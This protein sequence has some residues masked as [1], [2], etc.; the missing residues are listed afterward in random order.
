MFASVVAPYDRV[1]VGL[2]I[3][4]P[5]NHCL[6]LVGHSHSFYLLSFYACSCEDSFNT[7]GQVLYDLCG[8]MLEPALLTAYLFVKNDFL[9]H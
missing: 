4:I 9:I 5:T 2:S 1:V 6:P 7:F 3:L 8:I